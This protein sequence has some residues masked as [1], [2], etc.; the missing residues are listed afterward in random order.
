MMN[1]ASPDR[2]FSFSRL[3]HRGVGL[4]RIEFIVNNAIGV[5]PRALL[6]V[7]TLDGDLRDQVLAK[8]AG[9]PDGRTF[10]VRTLAEGIAT[11]AAAFA[12]ESVIVRLSDFKSNEYAHLLG[13]RRYEPVEENPMIGWRGAARYRSAEFRAAFALE[14]EAIRHVRDG[15]GL[16]NVEVMIPF[17]RTVGELREVL[18]IMAE[19][20]LERGRN[21]LR[22]IM[23][24]E[25]PS[26]AILAERFLE[27]V[28]GFS[29]GS[30]D[31]TQLT[32]ALDRDSGVVA[33]LFDE[34]DPAVLALIDM[35]ITAAKSAG[36]YVGICGQGPS[37]S[38]SFA[39]W[40]LERG[41]DSISLNPDTVLET[42]LFLAGQSVPAT[43]S[44]APSGAPDGAPAAVRTDVDD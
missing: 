11:I 19:E 42:W 17:V 34:E 39:R 27:Y 32:L 9:Y 21:A 30:N 20:G 1:V 10:Y 29:I 36:K 12:P 31:L 7:D 25:V 13:G 23:M 28:D 38:P 33:D 44:G 6:E 8:S 43:P 15:I 4:A 40:L 24:C 41:I 5:H 3:P 14:C 16:T 37:D 35:A 26:N 18:A 2:A 22:V